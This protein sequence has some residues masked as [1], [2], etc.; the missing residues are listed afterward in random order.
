MKM[1]SSTDYA[2]RIILYLAKKT[3]PISSSELIQYLSLSKR[4]L[5]QIIAKL[6]Q[7]GLVGTSMG[8]YG[9]YSLIVSPDRIS[10]RRIIEIMEKSTRFFPRASFEDITIDLQLTPDSVYGALQ[11]LW[12]TL[13]CKITI[14]YMIS[15]SVTD[16]QVFLKSIVLGLY[17]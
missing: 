5:H 14:E 9:G 10:L 4:Y 1:N 17:L 2:V 6:R 3:K 11:S 13:L 7:G 12:D 16:I 8:Y 15:S